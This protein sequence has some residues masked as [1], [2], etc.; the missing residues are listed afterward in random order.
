MRLG[1]HCYAL[2]GFAYLPPWAV[3]AGFVVGDE[4][5]LVIDCG[6]SLQ[7]AATILGY[8]RTARPGNVA[9]AID[10]ERHLDHVA[11]NELFR[12]QGLDVWGHPSIDRSDEEHAR[13]VAEYSLTVPDPV[14]RAAGEGRIPFAGTH[15]VPPNVRVEREQ[16]L[17]L[18]GVVA[19]VLL[20]PGHTPANLAVWIADDG[21]LYAGDTVVSDYAPNLESGGPWEW[22]QWLRALDRIEALAPGK[23]VPGHG[24]VLEGPEIGIEIGRI[25]R[26]LERALAED[27]ATR[28]R[29][30][31]RR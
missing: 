5:T 22:Q 23:L 2:T 10:T 19:Q 16:D 6:P 12:R 7:A 30:P 3:N 11:G 25:R 26:H 29:S 17:A 21:V 15:I 8:A 20:I 24:R 31:S 14:R 13:D 9:F 1:A 4:R 28:S 27:A 18:G